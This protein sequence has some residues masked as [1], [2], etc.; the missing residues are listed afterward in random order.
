MGMRTVRLHAGKGDIF[1]KRIPVIID[2]DPGIDDAVALLLALASPELDV[3]AITAV[4]G[5]VPL[6]RTL[7]NVLI[8]RERSGFTGV[9]VYAGCSRPLLRAPEYAAC[10]G[11]DGLGGMGGDGAAPL[12]RGAEEEHAV[13]FLIRVLHEAAR[14]ERPR[15]TLCPLAPLT[16]IALALIQAPDIVNG[17]ERI[18][19]MG[20]A[21]AE[22][23]NASPCAEF[24]ILS[25]PHAAQVVFSCGAPLV[26]AP[27]DLTRK[28]LATSERLAG[29]RAAGNP[30][31]EF[32]AD[33]LTAGRDIGS[34]PG[35][36]GVPLH[37][38]AV[39]GWL[40]HPEYFSGREGYVAVECASE[41]CM[42]YTMVDWFGQ[43][44]QP[45]NTLV[46]T[47]LDADAFFADLTERLRAY[48]RND[49]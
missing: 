6:E 2:T 33:L 32:A 44:G 27:L 22:Q 20:G 49:A 26:I 28:A 19:L 48:G 1:V 10:H 17:I 18:V 47:D 7:A 37:D 8:V 16:N 40:L 41:R 39:F 15:V 31:A 29:I 34:L 12:S 9:P 42:G 25:D 35:G 36:G 14:G 3:L 45:S 23:G 5:N 4:S 13:R 30:V 24:N 38:P 21:F 43:T 46:L 11:A